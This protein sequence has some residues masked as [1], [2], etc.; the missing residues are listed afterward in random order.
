MSGQPEISRFRQFQA[1]RT[2]NEEIES[3]EKIH[4]TVF[5]AATRTLPSGVQLLQLHCRYSYGTV[6]DW[7]G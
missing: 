2:I 1:W 3:Q 5:E 7:S 6:G 4:P